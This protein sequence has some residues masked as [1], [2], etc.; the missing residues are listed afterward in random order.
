MVSHSFDNRVEVLLQVSPVAISVVGGGIKLV[1]TPM[2]EVNHE[3]FRSEGV[4]VLS[5][6]VSLVPFSE[7]EAIDRRLISDRTG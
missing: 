4:K 6:S 5:G 3:T 7:N 2:T 1:W